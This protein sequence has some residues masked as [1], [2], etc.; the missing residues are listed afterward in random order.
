MAIHAFPLHRLLFAALLGLLAVA[1]ASQAARTS[2]DDGDIK[3]G[4]QCWTFRSLTF[5]ETLNRASNLGVKHLQIYVGQAIGGGLP[6]AIG[7]DLTAQERKTIQGWVK[8]RGLEIVSIGVTGAPDEAGW[9]KLVAFARAMGIR[10]IATEPEQELL[11]MIARV[12]KGTGIRIALHDHPAPSRYADPAVALA[13]VQPYGDNFGLCADTGHWVRDGRDPVAA[14]RQA[15]GRLIEIHFKDISEPAH[16][17]HDMPWGTGIGNAAGQIAELRRQK[18]KGYAFIEYEHNTPEL[19]AD[20]ARSI[21]FFRA[22]LRATPAD[23]I[24]G[25]VMPSG[26]TKDP[27]ALWRDS[28]ASSAGLWPAPKALLKPDLS[29]AE[30]PEGSWSWDGDVLVA[31]GGGDL[32]TKESYG[33]FALSL[34]FKVGAAGNSGVF[35]RTSDTVNWLHNAIEV[36]ILQGDAENPRHVVGSLF[37]VLAPARQ[38]E[39]EPDTWHQFVIVAQGSKIVVHLDGEKIIDADLNEWTTAGMNPDETPNKFQKAYRD[40]AREGRIGLQ[41]HGDPVAFRNILIETL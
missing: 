32:W 38:K 20:V 4:L 26:Y 8:D 13:A 28:R 39:I 17:A 34:E 9:K 35:L 18:F 19:E 37:D 31:H 24:A 27:A 29:N 6:G 12:V 10:T 36:Q 21:A 14:L 1:P 41:Y 15:E 2:A 30:F 5:H 11:P 23:L 25:N 22:A 16:V 7:P 40:M 33:D 3:L